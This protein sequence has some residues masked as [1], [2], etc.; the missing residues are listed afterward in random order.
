[1]RRAAVVLAA[2]AALACG[3]S[4]AAKK[5]INVVDADY[6][7]LQPGQTSLVDAAR[8]DLSRARDE[9]ARAKLRVSEAQNQDELAKSD[10]QAVAAAQTRA[11]ALAA[12][13]NASREPAALEQARAAKE[14]ADLRRRTA[15]AHVD[16]A[17]KLQA[18]RAAAV[19]AAERRVDYESARVELAKLHSMQQAQIPAAIKY[20]APRLEG[21]VAQARTDQDRADADARK[22]E[23]E[24]AASEQKWKALN[25][26]LQAQLGAGR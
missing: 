17:R 4:R 19:T 1:M 3:G 2:C 26:Q 10:L 15:D 25:Q 20:D 7:R 16:Y 23:A 8:A 9:L 21:Q 13:A 18:S 6:G 22:A 14:T 5:P 11:D 12:A 24:V